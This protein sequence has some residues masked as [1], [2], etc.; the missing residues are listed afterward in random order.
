M[1]EGIE[2][3]IIDELTAELEITD[4]LFNPALLAPKVRNA[5]R[6][7]KMKRNYEATSYSEKQIEK[8]LYNYYSVI[9]NLAIYDYN[10]IG[11][12]FQS[13]SSENSTNRTMVDRNSLLKDVHAFVKVL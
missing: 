8:D 4:K 12:E 7:V 10:T 6:E 11:M 3:E 2:Q 1:G 13:A 5:V 9:K